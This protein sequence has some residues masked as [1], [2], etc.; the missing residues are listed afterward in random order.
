MNERI[1]TL[2]IGGGQAGLST[3][4]YLKQH[5][6]E[7]L[8]LEK[9]DKIASPWRNERWDS[10]TLVTPNWAL[11]R[12]PESDNNGEPPDGFMPKDKI[13]RFF[14]SY[15][16]KHSLPVHYNTNVVSVEAEDNK[17]FIVRANNGV[18][19]VKN[20]IVASG[21]QHL[22]RVPEFSHK[23]SKDIMQIHSSSYKNPQSIPDGAVLIAGSGQSGTQIAEELNME[24][25]KVFLCVG[26][27]GRLP[28]RYRGKDIIK[29]L[30]EM[31]AFETT[32]EQLPPGLRKFGPI[33]QLTG[34]RGGYTINLH[35]F[36]RDGITLLG[37]LKDAEKNKIFIENDL[38]K[39]LNIVDQ[40]EKE[41]VKMIDKYIQERKMDLPE[42]KLPEPDYGYKQPLI[43]EIDLKAENVKTIIWAGGYKW[44]YS[45]VKLPVFDND[46]FPVQNR[47]VTDVP[48]L[49]FVGL[50]WMPSEKTGFL[51]GVSEAAKYIAD[52]IYR[53]RF[54]ASVN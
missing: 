47:G 29:W 34:R 50:P 36:A 51:V 20:V 54:Q 24:G 1:N 23:I 2:I 52:Y 41:I 45:F 43:K 16:E 30:E 8:I 4:Y 26:T 10:F 49:C 19:E 28:R 39:S 11:F 35:Q 48:G 3:S 53:K 12:V 18:Y 32:P 42:E 37:H 31:G 7:H 25:R 38:H 40:F 27:A 33:P 5:G 17:G 13:V 44:D 9:S 21:F 15:V 22:P 6:V 46:R 14:E